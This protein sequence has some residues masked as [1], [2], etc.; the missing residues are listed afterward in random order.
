MDSV[1][2]SLE[3]CFQEY[4][5]SSALVLVL[6]R[7]TGDFSYENQHLQRI[8]E[9]ID[10]LKALWSLSPA[11]PW[12]CLPISLLLSN[13]FPWD[14]D[15]TTKLSISAAKGA[16]VKGL[17]IEWWS[18]CTGE[19]HHSSRWGLDA[20][21]CDKEHLSQVPRVW[22]DSFSEDECVAILRDDVR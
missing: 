15:G 6:K 18:V 11:A 5:S 1:S 9:S 10:M 7:L 19:S 14:F 22:K 20:C 8:R 4:L 17:K 2:R 12:L 21:C 16:E 13:L 3:I